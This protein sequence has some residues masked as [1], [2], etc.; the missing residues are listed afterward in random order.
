MLHIIFLILKILGLLILGI[1]GLIIIAVAI[2]LLAPAGYMLEVSGKDTLESMQGRL[3]FHWLLHLLSG[4]L[5]YEDG[6]FAW[7]MR[8]GWKKFGSG[9]EKEDDTDEMESVP[10]SFG[11]PEKMPESRAEE[12]S[13]KQ[14]EAQTEEKADSGYAGVKAEHSKTEKKTDIRKTKQKHSLYER[15]KEFWEKIK[16]TFQKI[17]D[18][19]RSLV[20]KKKRLT[21]FIQN[22]VHKSAFFK[23]IRELRRFL[24]TL[25]P[26]KA[27]VCAEFGFTDPAVTGYV[28][29]LISM[30]YPFIGEYAEIRPDF[31]HKILRGRVYV[32]GRIRALHAVSFALRLL[33]NKNVRT[34]YRHIRKFKL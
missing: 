31:E 3:K 30:I 20:K 7:R 15:L 28:L 5:Y 10:D 23:V 16:Y 13:E 2:V 25:R 22:E 17:C 21:A 4:E 8:A 27:D 18:N 33:L 34:T 14:P 32:K 1:F 12:T 19:I 26:R 24:K 6:R 29:A 11:K 9:M